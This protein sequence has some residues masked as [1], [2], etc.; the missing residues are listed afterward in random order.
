MITL[1]RETWYDTIS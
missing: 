1:K